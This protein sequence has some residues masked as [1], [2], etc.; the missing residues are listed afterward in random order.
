MDRI[1]ILPFS[2]QLNW[3]ERIFFFL[4]TVKISYRTCLIFSIQVENGQ[5]Y[6]RR[7]TLNEA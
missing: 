6:Q 1:E 3:A 2:T 4:H 7:T 5:E